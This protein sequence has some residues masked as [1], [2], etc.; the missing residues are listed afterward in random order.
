MIHRIR[1]TD[2]ET[3]QETNQEIFRMVIRK[4]TN[5]S[6][7][8]R[9]ASVDVWQQRHN[10]RSHTHLNHDIVPISERDSNLEYVIKLTICLM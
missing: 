5:K 10:N 8:S 7:S 9:S 3:N 4:L 2:R 1:Q 6:V